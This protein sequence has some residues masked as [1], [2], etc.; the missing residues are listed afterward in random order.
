MR[1]LKDIPHAQY[2]I[3]LYQWN[4]K[5]IVKFEAGGQYEQIYKIDET[6]F[7]SVEELESILD[8]KFISTISGRFQQMHADTQES[9]KRHDLLF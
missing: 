1:Y 7:E 5:Y 2:K 6:E 8:E 3:G 9:M 4:G